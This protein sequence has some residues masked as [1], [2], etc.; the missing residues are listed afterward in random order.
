MSEIDANLDADLLAETENYMVW[1]SEV[2]GETLYHVEL[3]TVS[4]HLAAD[5]WD[6]FLTLIKLVMQD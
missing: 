6:E 2:D 4:L 1:T 5:E 3:G